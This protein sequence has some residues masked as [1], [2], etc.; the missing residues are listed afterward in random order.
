M[1]LIHCALGTGEPCKNTME[2]SAKARAVF[3]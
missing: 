3:S 1:I 2:E